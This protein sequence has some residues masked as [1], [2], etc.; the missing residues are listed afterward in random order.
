M[1]FQQDQM[2]AVLD[3][4]HQLMGNSSAPSEKVTSLYRSRYRPTPVPSVPA[5]V[6]Y[7]PDSTYGEIDETSSKTSNI[8][9]KPHNNT[10]YPHIEDDKV[11]YRV[12]HAFENDMGDTRL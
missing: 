12:N 3:Q 9:D 8:P 4:A 5:Y 6:P 10:L 11:K 2:V 1:S 7:I